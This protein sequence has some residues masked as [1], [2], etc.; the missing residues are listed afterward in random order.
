M[1]QD[2][3]TAATCPPMPS[4]SLCAFAPLREPM[5]L[6]DRRQ[7]GAGARGKAGCSWLFLT[8]IFSWLLFPIF[9]ENFLCEFKWLCRIWLLFDNSQKTASFFVGTASV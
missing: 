1:P 5:L 9:G 3:R 7:P 6:S 4:S 8:E 2:S